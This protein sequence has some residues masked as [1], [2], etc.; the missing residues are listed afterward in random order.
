M[1]VN[2]EQNYKLRPQY[3][4]EQRRKNKNIIDGGQKEDSEQS[5]GHVQNTNETGTVNGKRASCARCYD[6]DNC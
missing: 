3:K 2:L 5:D 1:G 4:E 6:E